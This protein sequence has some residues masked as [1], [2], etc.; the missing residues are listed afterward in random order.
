MLCTVS[1]NV[2]Y[3]HG[4]K[5]TAEC[6]NRSNF[7]YSILKKTGNVVASARWTGHSCN[8]KLPP[9]RRAVL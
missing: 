1:L 3:T 8:K 5:D 6:T 2:I 9:T 7:A 4:W